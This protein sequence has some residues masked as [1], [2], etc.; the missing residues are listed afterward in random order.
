MRHV[1]ARLTAN[2][3]VHIDDAGRLHASNIEAVPGP[4]SL[5]DLRRRC[6]AML[7]RVSTWVS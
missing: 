1:A 4:P 7:P 5:T 2:A 6:E 3:E